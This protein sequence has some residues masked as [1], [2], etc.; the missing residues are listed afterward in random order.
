MEIVVEA[1]IKNINYIDS[2]EIKQIIKTFLGN[3]FQN[4]SEEI[5]QNYKKLYELGEASIIPLTET[6]LSQDWSTV[7]NRNQVRVLT[8]VLSLL[9]DINEE[10]CQNTSKII[11]EK[12][13][14]NALTRSINSITSFTLNDY[15]Q[16]NKCGVNVYILKEL[17]NIDFIEKK[18]EEWLFLTSKKDIEK[19]N[20]IYI[21]S[22]DKE[23]SYNGTYMPILS[24]IRIVW[25]CDYKYNFLLKWINLFF[26]EFTLYHEIGHHYYKHVF[27]Q[28]I[29]QEK[30]A[31]KYASILIAKSHP[32][33]RKIIKIIKYFGVKKK[34]SDLLE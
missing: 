21:I 28:D 1:Q 9:N 16:Y 32:T 13:C 25:K 6:I 2:K 17:K 7:D 34:K 5:Y 27:G 29:N 8:G 18:I 24:Y 20:R 4:L 12:G 23:Y 11:I 22:Y 15:T 31:D 26:V 19:I 10:A 14:S 3:L 33:L 30:E